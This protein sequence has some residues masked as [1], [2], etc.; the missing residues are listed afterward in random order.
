MA[1]KRARK[2]KKIKT[3]RVKRTK[4]AKK[5]TQVRK[6]FTKEIEH[7][8]D[9]AVGEK[10]QT[11][12]KKVNSTIAIIALILNLLILPGL[13]SLI[14]GKT[15]QAAIQIALM[16]CGILLLTFDM[17]LL[18]LRFI[19]AILIAGAWLWALVTSIIILKHAE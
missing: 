4:L 9:I 19:A 15:R 8:I 7:K 11:E 1:K 5:Q 14:G 13:G 6:D 2:I 10:L 12:H 3:A 18:T 17:S 16:L